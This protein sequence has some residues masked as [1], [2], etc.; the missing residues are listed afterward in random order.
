MK[1]NTKKPY[2]AAE[3]SLL[4]FPAEDLM[5]GSP[6]ADEAFYGDIDSFISG[7]LKL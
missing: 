7:V 3:L 1:N 4:V 6:E 2:E 5:T